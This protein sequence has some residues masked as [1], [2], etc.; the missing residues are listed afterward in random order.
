MASNKKPAGFTVIELLASMTV[1]I[2]VVMM[3]TRIFTETTGIWAR[4][5]KQIQ[6]AVEGRVIMDFIVKEM[7]QAVADDVV[8]FKLNSGVGSPP[9]YGVNAYGVQSDE[10]CFVAMVRSGDG[11]YRRT[12]NQFVY[13]ISPML[14]EQNQ[15]IPNRFRLVRT[16]R[17]QSMYNNPANLAKSAYGNRT[18]WQDMDPDYDDDGP[19]SGTPIETIAENVAGFE[20]WAWNPAADRYEPGYGSSDFDDLL[21]LWVDIYLE[22]LS[23]DDAV[24]SAILMD[25]DPNLGAEYISRSVKR[26]TTRVYFPNRERALAF[27]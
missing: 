20:V 19:D 8:T 2:F 22:L 13:F 15:A 12:S 3:M 17:T 21:P 25:A 24:R 9:Q 5:A 16:R 18:W 14:D 27:D 6:S 11:G 7:T 26:Y 1:L 4:G 23:E 10:V